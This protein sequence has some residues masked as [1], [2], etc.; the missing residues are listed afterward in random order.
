[1]AKTSVKRTDNIYYPY[2]YV[3]S[4]V[5]CLLAI[6]SVIWYNADIWVLWWYLGALALL[7][8]LNIVRWRK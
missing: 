8:V 4:V 6:I 7:L 3:Y 5:L 2:L 1:M